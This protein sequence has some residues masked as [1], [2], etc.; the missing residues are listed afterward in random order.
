MDV[1]PKKIQTNW[2]FVRVLKVNPVLRKVR[3]R[4]GM[5]EWGR[6]RQREMEWKG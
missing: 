6:E 4:E 5:A 3:E 2:P 1:P